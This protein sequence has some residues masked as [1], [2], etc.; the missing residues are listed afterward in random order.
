M[1]VYRQLDTPTKVD[2]IEAFPE[3]FNIKFRKGQ[4]VWSVVHGHG[5]IIA[6]DLEDLTRPVEVEYKS[7]ESSYVRSYT[8]AGKIDELDPTPEIYDHPVRVIHE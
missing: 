3:A 1:R 5:I 2:L 7:S 4:E 6:V 8:L